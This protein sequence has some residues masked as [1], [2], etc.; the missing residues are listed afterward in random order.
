MYVFRSLEKRLLSF[1]FSY[2]MHEIDNIW[3]S[4]ELYSTS[5][6]GSLKTGSIISLDQLTNHY[7]PLLVVFLNL[8]SMILSLK[9]T[10]L[11]H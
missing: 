4:R 8:L 9:K 1:I 5:A 10:A 6:A 11:R 2:M 7:V 3:V